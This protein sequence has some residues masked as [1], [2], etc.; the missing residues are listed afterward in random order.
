MG[1][2]LH[3]HVSRWRSALSAY[4]YVGQQ[5]SLATV[6]DSRLRHQAGRDPSYLYWHM[7]L[8]SSPVADT[9]SVRWKRVPGIEPLHCLERG[10]ASNGD[11]PRYLANLGSYLAR[12]A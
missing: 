9:V 10:D 5:S 1:S 3:V 4:M 12:V 11:V 7:D 6:D 8:D 2:D